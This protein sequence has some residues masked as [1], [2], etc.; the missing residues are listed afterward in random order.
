M[1]SVRKNLNI[2]ERHVGINLRGTTCPTPLTLRSKSLKCD[3]VEVLSSSKGSRTALS[4]PL[5]AGKGIGLV[6]DRLTRYGYIIY[7]ATV[8]A[9]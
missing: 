5:V 6:R 8:R 9:R 2:D 4:L 7:S 3:V 1:D